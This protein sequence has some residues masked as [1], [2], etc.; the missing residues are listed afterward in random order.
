MR[1]QT[2]ERTRSGPQLGISVA[3][4]V[5]LRVLLAVLCIAA[6]CRAGRGMG[7]SA[8]AVDQDR[9]SQLAGPGK[10]CSTQHAWQALDS[11][12]LVAAAWAC[13]NVPVLVAATG[14]SDP[15]ACQ[16]CR[17]ALNQ[18][19]QPTDLAFIGGGD[20]SSS[21]HIDTAVPLLVCASTA[22]ARLWAQLPAGLPFDAALE[23]LKACSK[24]EL[25]PLHAGC[26]ASTQHVTDASTWDALCACPAS[27]GEKGGQYLCDASAAQMYA[28]PCH[29]RCLVRVSCFALLTSP[30]PPACWSFIR[31]HLSMPSLTCRV[32]KMCQRWCRARHSF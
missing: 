7:D 19:L 8:E 24:L 10:V 25:G 1:Q 16:Q 12:A 14:T 27:E 32:W 4:L 30:T 13:A 18:V 2:Q 3:D 29:A 31:T 9:R 20:G 17:C 21:S 26:Q 28:S 11:S 6:C 15:S 5:G 23:G 22:I